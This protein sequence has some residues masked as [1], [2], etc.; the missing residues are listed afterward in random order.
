MD[1]VTL[2]D[3]K[4]EAFIRQTTVNKILR[5]QLLTQFKKDITSD[6]VSNPSSSLRQKKQEYSE[7][8]DVTYGKYTGDS[9]QGRLFSKLGHPVDN[10]LVSRHSG[11]V[12]D[13][14]IHRQF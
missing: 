14:N 7:N 9:I 3:E 4:V 12:S 13:G 8:N 1:S 11:I 6:N 2:H 10:R 5:P